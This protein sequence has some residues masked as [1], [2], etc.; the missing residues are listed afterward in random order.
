MSG[1]WCKFQRNSPIRTRLPDPGYLNPSI[2][3]HFYIKLSSSIN[4]R[5]EQPRK[6]NVDIVAPVVIFL[7]LTMLFSKSFLG[8]STVTSRQKKK[9]K[10][11]RRKKR[12]KA[13]SNEYV[14]QSTRYLLPRE[15]EPSATFSLFGSDYDLEYLPVIETPVVTSKQPSPPR[16]V[17]SYFISQC[18]NQNIWLTFCLILLLHTARKIPTGLNCQYSLG[19]SGA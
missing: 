8:T 2:I 12:R 6:S 17:K 7:C 16:L 15:M 11:R 3:P 1:H 10:R 9:R 13:R 19:F 4:V 18:F 14:H 5:T